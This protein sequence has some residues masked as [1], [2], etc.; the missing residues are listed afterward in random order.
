EPGGT[1]SQIVRSCHGESRGRHGH[2]QGFECKKTISPTPA[3][4]RH[5]SRRNVGCGDPQA[6]KWMVDQTK[7]PGRMPGF[8]RLVAT[9]LHPAVDRSCWGQ[10]RGEFPHLIPAD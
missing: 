4:L 8:V 3:Y 6:A 7:D 2:P 9:V 10:S 5:R 1:V